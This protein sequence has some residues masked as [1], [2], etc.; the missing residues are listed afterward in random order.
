M[1]IEPKVGKKKISVLSKGHEKE[2]DFER[3]TQKAPKLPTFDHPKH[4][5]LPKAASKSSE[6]FQNK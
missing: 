5:S 2:G 6:M 4:I 3:C 1:N